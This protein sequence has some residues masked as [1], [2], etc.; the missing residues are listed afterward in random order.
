M[1][2]EKHARLASYAKG[3]R[4]LVCTFGHVVRIQLNNFIR[5]KPYRKN[6]KPQLYPSGAVEK[7]IAAS[8][9]W[10]NRFGLDILT[11]PITRASLI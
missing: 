8:K 1:P 3:T 10:K 6:L 11:V 5:N 4:F 9:Y 2:V 7:G